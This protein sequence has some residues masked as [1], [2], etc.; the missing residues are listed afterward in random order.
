MSKLHVDATLV[1]AH[2][3]AELQAENER[4]LRLL[5]DSQYLPA[6]IANLRAALSRI[7]AAIPGQGRI[8]DAIDGLWTDSIVAAVA[9][10]AVDDVRDR[11]VAMRSPESQAQLD[12]LL[13]DD[14]DDIL[15]GGRC[16]CSP[17]Y[18]VAPGVHAAYCPLAGGSTEKSDSER[19]MDIG[20]LPYMKDKR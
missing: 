8:P 9:Q 11:M 6:V 3:M 10:L 2:R 16:A 13:A 19:R 4:L 17:K 12:A 7:V 5:R 15:D 20:A 18:R 14:E 1:A